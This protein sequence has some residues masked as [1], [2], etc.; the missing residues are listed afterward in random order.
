MRKEGGFEAYFCNP[1]C[2]TVVIGFK[3]AYEYPLIYVIVS[4]F[5][6]DLEGFSVGMIFEIVVCQFRKDWFRR[7]WS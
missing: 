6:V 2:I 1:I 7:D 3:L 4:L 5:L